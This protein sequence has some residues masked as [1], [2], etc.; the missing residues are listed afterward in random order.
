MES[1]HT[2]KFPEGDVILTQSELA[3]TRLLM[4][5]TSGVK[6]YNKNGS[7]I[8]NPFEEFPESYTVDLT[9]DYH[10][11]LYDLSC[12]YVMN[13]PAPSGREVGEYLTY[14]RPKLKYVCDNIPWSDSEYRYCG[15]FHLVEAEDGESDNEQVF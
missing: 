13:F 9:Q 4:Y 5:L 11:L 3:K 6:C 8:E 1:L 2:I 12:H 10:W 14:V 7:F 15:T